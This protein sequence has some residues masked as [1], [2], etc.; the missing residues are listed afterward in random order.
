MVE[1]MFFFVRIMTDVIQSVQDRISA[2]FQA[3]VQLNRLPTDARVAE[4]SQESNVAV[5]SPRMAANDGD[6]GTGGQSARAERTQRR[7]NDGNGGDAETGGQSTRSERAQ[8]RRNR[9][10]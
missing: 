1:K 10:Q 6:A 3:V 5:V 9:P 8:R 2:P 4:Q 7:R